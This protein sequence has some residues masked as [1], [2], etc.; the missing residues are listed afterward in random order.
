M[1][2]LGELTGDYSSIRSNIV[3]SKI[4]EKPLCFGLQN[5]KTSINDNWINSKYNI[6]KFYSYYR[7]M[8]K[9]LIYYNNNII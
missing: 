3:M 6:N 9:F 4:A 8:I 5:N 7:Y 1:T 2:D